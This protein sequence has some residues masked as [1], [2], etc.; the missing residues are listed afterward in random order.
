[1]IT[2]TDGSGTM[3]SNTSSNSFFRFNPVQDRLEEGSVEASK[4][5]EGWFDSN[6]WDNNGIHTE[7]VENVNSVTTNAADFLST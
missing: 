4:R 5:S 2:T 1:M 7:V 6:T 3:A